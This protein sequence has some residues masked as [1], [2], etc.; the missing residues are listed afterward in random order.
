MKDIH[1]LSAAG[2]YAIPQIPSEVAIIG[3]PRFSSRPTTFRTLTVTEELTATNN[4]SDITVPYNNVSELIAN[5]SSSFSQDSLLVFDLVAFIVDLPFAGTI[6]T[7]HNEL[8]RHQWSFGGYDS[9][10]S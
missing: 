7:H 5:T 4:I 9:G 2:S 10:E 1:R 8:S 6:T 3:L